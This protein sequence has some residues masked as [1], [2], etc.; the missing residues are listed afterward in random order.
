MIS[1]SE[2]R[3]IAALANLLPNE[4]ELKRFATQLNSI[5]DY[6]AKLKQVDVSTVAPTSHMHGTKNVFRD[7]ELV[8]SMSIDDAL[9]NA[10]DK[11]GRF[12]RVPLIIDSEGGE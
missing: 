9:R 7:D 11:S 12:F 5:L 8:S 3:K 10:P 4:E 2:V 1:D 6:V